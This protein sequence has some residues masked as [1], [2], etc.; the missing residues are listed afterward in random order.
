M[1]EL[2]KLSNKISTIVKHN[3]KRFG[4]TE[5]STLNSKLI[6]AIAGLTIVSETHKAGVADVKSV[7]C[8]RF[9][10]MEMQLVD[11]LYSVL[12]I[13]GQHKLDIDSALK[14]YMTR[15]ESV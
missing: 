2:N 9:S 4:D 13:A 10:N 8:D 6:E 5:G 14:F 7:S 1:S 12:D 11:V 3:R 15:E